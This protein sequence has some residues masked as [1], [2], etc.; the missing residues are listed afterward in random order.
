MCVWRR[1]PRLPAELRSLRWGGGVCLLGCVLQDAGE[2][3]ERKD[4]ALVLGCIRGW[5]G[6][7]G[8]LMTEQQATQTEEAAQEESTRAVL[9]PCR[10]RAEKEKERNPP[11]ASL[12]LL[13]CTR[14]LRGGVRARALSAICPWPK[15]ADAANGI[16]R[17]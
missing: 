16:A 4:N 3:K 2:G 15:A 5:M 10:E 9:F 17:A 1:K 6:I 11:T 13:P 7:E 12:V 8:R 14:L